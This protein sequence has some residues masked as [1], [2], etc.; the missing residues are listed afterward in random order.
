MNTRK[1]IQSIKEWQQIRDTSDTDILIVKV[2]PICPISRG[3]ERRVDRWLDAQE[4]ELPVQVIKVDVIS[5]RTLSHHLSEE[6]GIL[7]QS[8]QAIWFTPPETV[9]WHTSHHRITGA[10]LDAQLT[11]ARTRLS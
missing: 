9:R 7:H 1:R 6:L 10:A 3:V 5:A 2:S 4:S 11:E 8:P